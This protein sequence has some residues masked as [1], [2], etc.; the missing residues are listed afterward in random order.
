MK[1]LFSL[2]MLGLFCTA[3]NAQPVR[4]AV[5]RGQ[6]RNQLVRDQATIDRDR[7]ADLGVSVSDVAATLQMLVA[8][9]KGSTFPEGGE[10]Y[11]IR[12]RAEQQFR[13]DAT[14]MNLMNVPS[15]KYGNVPLASVV[16]WKDST[17]PSRINRYG[18]ERQITL[19]A[20]AAPGKGDDAVVKNIQT[21][22]AELKPPPN[23]RSASARGCWKR[24]KVKRLMNWAVH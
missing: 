10:E 11:D 5:E 2:L 3:A 12:L 20:N 1:T 16:K 13:L 21:K 14:A 4:N 6:D 17:A 9:V 15:V 23:Y 7:A 24:D 8:G 22:F 18:R 19:L